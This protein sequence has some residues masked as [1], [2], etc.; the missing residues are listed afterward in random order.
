MKKCLVT[1]VLLASVVPAIAR[2]PVD[3]HGRHAECQMVGHNLAIRDLPANDAMI[4]G[5]MNDGGLI[6]HRIVRLNTSKNGKW[7][8]IGDQEEGEGG[9]W[10]TFSRGWVSSDELA[11]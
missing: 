9:I 10:E 6:Q 4:V 1:P 3:E 8:F 11:C 2:D 7:T 5:H